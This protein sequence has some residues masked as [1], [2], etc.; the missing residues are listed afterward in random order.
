M[1]RA[2][3]YSALKLM[4]LLLLVSCSGDI[5]SS[6]NSPPNIT[7]L[8]VDKTIVMVNSKTKVQ[9]FADDAD[10]D[11]LQYEWI[12]YPGSVTGSGS[13]IQWIA[14]EV[15]ASYPLIC[16]VTDG[17]GGVAEASL[18][19][20]VIGN[21]SPIYQ[22][23]LEDFFPSKQII[24]CDSTIVDDYDDYSPPGVY[25]TTIENYINENRTSI[26]L[27]DYP[28]WHNDYSLI[29]NVEFNLIFVNGFYNSRSGWNNFYSKHPNSR[30]LA[31][32]SKIGINPER[33]QAW[34]YLA[35]WY[36]INNAGGWY[37][38]LSKDLEWKIDFAFYRWVS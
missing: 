3:T 1:T 25:S 11:G 19:F 20:S 23:I 8:E 34:V 7:S 22:L 31:F 9:C 24:I 21:A 5:I 15:G 33:N 17:H 12:S 38:L 6:F 27:R 30:G 32:F 2:I 28:Y 18:N 26:R 4:C 29:S 37:F 13:V 36:G 16:R 10:D 35:I 14:P